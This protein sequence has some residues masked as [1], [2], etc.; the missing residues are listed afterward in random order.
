MKAPCEG[1]FVEAGL[2]TSDHVE[3]GQLLG[4]IIRE[5]SL[6]TV[7]IRAPATGYLWNYGCFRDHSDVAL[8][9]QHPWADAGDTLASVR[10]P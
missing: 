10:E 8:P 6:E 4:H 7:E 2:E 9:P 5:D 3:E 1:L